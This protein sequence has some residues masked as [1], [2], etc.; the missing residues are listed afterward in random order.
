MNS[1]RFVEK[2]AELIRKPSISATGEGIEE[3]AE[4]VRELMEKIDWKPRVIQE[5]NGKIQLFHGEVKSA[6]RIG[7]CFFYNHYNAQ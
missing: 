3:C 7:R 5:K 2:L 6:N 4:K 1:G